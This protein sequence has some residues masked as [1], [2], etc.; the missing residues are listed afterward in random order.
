MP[1]RHADFAGVAGTDGRLGR[2]W[3]RSAAAGLPG[4]SSLGAGSG[5][6]CAGLTQHGGSL[7][8]WRQS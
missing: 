5:T 1:L 6:A 4:T 8:A 7:A 3:L 2:D